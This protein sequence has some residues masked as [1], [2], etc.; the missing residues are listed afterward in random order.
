MH[1]TERKIIALLLLTDK[2]FPTP[3][4]SAQTVTKKH[5]RVITGKYF[6]STGN[7]EIGCAKIEAV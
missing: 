4:L 2:L 5:R 6:F 1:K 3:T 7:T